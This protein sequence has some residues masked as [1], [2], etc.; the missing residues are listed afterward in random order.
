MSVMTMLQAAQGGKLFSH[1]AES[2]DLDEAETRKAMGLLCPAIAGRLK[3]AA[4]ADDDLLQSLLDLIEDG[5]GALPLEETDAVTGEEAVMV[6]VVDC[7][8]HRFGVPPSHT[9]TATTQVAAGVGPVG[10]KV[11]TPVPATM[12]PPQVWLPSRLQV[13]PGPSASRRVAL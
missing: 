12:L 1:V 7:E 13:W 5:A 3:D 10:V 2:L 4:A 9:W 8:A 6:T 11:N